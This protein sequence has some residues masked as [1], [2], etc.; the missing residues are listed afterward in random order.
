MVGFVISRHF[1]RAAVTIR[2]ICLLPACETAVVQSMV[3]RR[4]RRLM[5]WTILFLRD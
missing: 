5:E 3:C 2:E 1:F 4:I